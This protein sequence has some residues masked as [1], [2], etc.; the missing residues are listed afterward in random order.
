M[1]DESALA[2]VHE[3]PNGVILLAS[4]HP[5]QQNTLTRRLTRPMFHAVFRAARRLLSPRWAS[6]PE[7]R[8]R[9]KK[10]Q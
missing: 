9:L 4:Y 6:R 3:L 8:R 1:R 5:S 2:Q 10:P 7:V